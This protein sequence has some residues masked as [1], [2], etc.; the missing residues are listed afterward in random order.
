MSILATL[1]E[2]EGFPETR[3]PGVA[4]ATCRGSSGAVLQE[5]TERQ[6]ASQ[7]ALTDAALHVADTTA[8]V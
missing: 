2:A 8:Q 6:R 7:D 3:A 1:L 5:H 4:D